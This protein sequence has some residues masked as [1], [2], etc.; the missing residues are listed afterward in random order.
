MVALTGF[1]G[2]FSTL[3]F[4]HWGMLGIAALVCFFLRPETVIEKVQSSGMSAAVA[5][6]LLGV[7]LFGTLL[8]GGLSDSFIY[9]RS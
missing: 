8:F 3:T 9:F 2:S 7:V 5:G 1:G 6:V 4:E